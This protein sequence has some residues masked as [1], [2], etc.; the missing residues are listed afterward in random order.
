MHVDQPTLPSDRKFG[1]TFAVVIA[2]LAWYGQRHGASKTS[3]FI[4]LG[5]AASFA[6]LAT[7]LP[8]ALRPLN[9]LWFRIG[10]VLGRVMNPIV[11]GFIY[12]VLVTPFSFVARLFGHDPLRLRPQDKKSYWIERAPPGP[13]PESFK[14]PF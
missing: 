6:T 4:K 3:L 9:K 7:L 1:W 5:L 12:F 8:I 2:L 14:H 11:L 10:L 13:A